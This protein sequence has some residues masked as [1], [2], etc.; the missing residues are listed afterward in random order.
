[1]WTFVRH[2]GV[3]PNN[4]TAKRAI[5]PGVL[6]RKRS[7]GTHSPEG[8]QFVEAMMTVVDTLKQ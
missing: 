1:L 8:S 3:E 6:W 5:R 2:A 4:H 7:F